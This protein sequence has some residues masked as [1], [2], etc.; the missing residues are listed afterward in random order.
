MQKVLN[1]KERKLVM[2]AELGLCVLVCFDMPTFRRFRYS[3]GLKSE[4][5]VISCHSGLEILEEG[6]GRCVQR[7][8]K[9]CLS[10]HLLLLRTFIWSSFYLAAMLSS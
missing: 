10:S 9:V 7:Y 5:I 8:Y 1:V 2:G 4:I 3:F 6:S